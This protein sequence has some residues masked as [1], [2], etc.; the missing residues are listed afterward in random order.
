MATEG[1]DRLFIDD[2]KGRR[3]AEQFR[4]ENITTLGIIFELSMSGILTKVDYVKNVTNFGA[5]GWIG[6]G[7]IQEFTQRGQEL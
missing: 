7:I 4:V 1:K 5:L 2:L 3:L 6:G